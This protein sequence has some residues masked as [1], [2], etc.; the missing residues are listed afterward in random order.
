MFRFGKNLGILFCQIAEFVIQTAKALGKK[1]PVKD[2]EY[3][4]DRIVSQYMEQ[5]D[6][7]VA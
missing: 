3:I 2:S 1:I 5:L 6:G 7:D 4:A